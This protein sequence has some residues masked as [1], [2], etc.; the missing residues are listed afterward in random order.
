M[1][2]KVQ[3]GFYRMQYKCVNC[4]KLFQSDIRRGAVAKGASGS[5]PHCG[6]QTGKPGVGH[7]E[8]VLPN[9]IVGNQEILHG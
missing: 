7:H 9:V 4:G 6:I 1:D 5:C 2:D 8:A 3:E